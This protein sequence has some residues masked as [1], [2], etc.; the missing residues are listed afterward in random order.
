MASEF[1]ERQFESTYES[2]R[3]KPLIE[4]GRESWSLALWVSIASGVSSF[5]Y[6][7]EMT[8][9]Q[10]LGF[11]PFYFLAFLA[12]KLVLLRWLKRRYADDEPQ[13]RPNRPPGVRP[14]IA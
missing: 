12:M 5:F 4:L 11:L 14:R 1:W 2:D 3:D 13:S 10:F 9:R 8:L 7:P 6:G